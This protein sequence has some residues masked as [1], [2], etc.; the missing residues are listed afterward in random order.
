MTDPGRWL[1]ER[2]AEAPPALRRAA[3]SVQRDADA[4][5]RA[6][7]S[8]QRAFEA[9]LRALAE[10]LLAA[11]KAGPP[12]HETALTLLAADALI[13]LA[14]E[15]VGETEPRRLGEMR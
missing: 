12:T 9:E 8:G 11:A 4:V 15:W 10:D 5:Q 13:T 6:A 7:C 1:E 2:L 14:C 3:C